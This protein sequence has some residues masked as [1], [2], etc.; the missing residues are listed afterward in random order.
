MTAHAF[1]SAVLALLAS[2][3]GGCVSDPCRGGEAELKAGTSRDYLD[4]PLAEVSLSGE[5]RRVPMPTA[6][7]TGVPIHRFAVWNDGK[8][9]GGLMAW[10]GRGED[11]NASTSAV[12]DEATLGAFVGR[13]VVV[14]GRPEWVTGVG[15]GRSLWV[16]RLVCASTA[17]PPPPPSDPL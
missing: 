6:S 5:L 15:T 11:P 2:L 16:G 14:Y 4:H 9:V 10:G 1:F 3:A 8:P 13:R 12:E 7:I 17:R